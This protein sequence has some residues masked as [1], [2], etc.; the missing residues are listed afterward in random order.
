MTSQPAVRRTAGA[1]FAE[2]DGRGAR[3][4]RVAHAGDYLGLCAFHV[5]LDGAQSGQ[6]IGM[7]RYP[8]VDGRLRDVDRAIERKIG[9]ERRAGL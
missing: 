3:R 7:R 9:G 1:G 4:E 8:R 5:D 2:E 6:Q